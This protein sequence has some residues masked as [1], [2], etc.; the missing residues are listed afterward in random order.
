MYLN[1]SEAK[2]ALE[3][4]AKEHTDDFKLY[5]LKRKPEGYKKVSVLFA[6]KTKY[7]EENESLFNKLMKLSV[8][9]EG[10][11]IIG[12]EVT[13]ENRALKEIF[14]VECDIHIFGV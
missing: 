1:E 11:E 13:E 2:E 8:D 5:P 7:A 9:K 10:V 3:S 4:I 14:F 6:L 12:S